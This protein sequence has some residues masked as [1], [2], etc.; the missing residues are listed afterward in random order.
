VN[1]HTSE[2]WEAII[3][4]CDFHQKSTLADSAG[5]IIAQFGGTGPHVANTARAEACVNA[6]AGMDDPAAELTRLRSRAAEAHQWEEMA[7]RTGLPLKPEGAEAEI[8]R[9]RR[10]EQLA[11][12][13]LDESAQAAKEN[14]K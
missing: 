8:T 12:K 10:V 1:K 7:E 2:P 5:N 6:C 13:M 11:Q 4:P 9:L 3:D 14:N